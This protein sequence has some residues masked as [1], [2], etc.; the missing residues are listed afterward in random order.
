MKNDVP[1][2]KKVAEAHKACVTVILAL[3][4]K[5]ILHEHEPAQLRSLAKAWLIAGQ[6]ARSPWHMAQLITALDDE[7]EEE[8][9]PL[10]EWGTHLLKRV[11]TKPLP[12]VKKSFNPF[13]WEEL[14]K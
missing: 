8:G 5:Y 12:K 13:V 6:E 4:I 7:A 10:S 14:P 1:S 9:V 2:S 3:F 11:R